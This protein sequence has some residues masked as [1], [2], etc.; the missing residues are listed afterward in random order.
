MNDLQSIR[1]A[2]ANGHTHSTDELAELLGWD[3]LKVRWTVT[4]LVSLG[5]VVPLP[6]R[7]SL[8]S[9]GDART[10]KVRMREG[11][12]EEEK[13]AHRRETQRKYYANRKAKLDASKSQAQA[14]AK[15]AALAEQKRMA[16]QEAEA[17]ALAAKQSTVQVFTPVAD[18]TMVSK[19]IANRHPLAMAWG[20]VA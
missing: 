20:G 14:K 13:V 10:R 12:T 4:K 9:L 8:T 6:K 16:K 17:A 18:D 2:L 15:R 19:A 11:M 1:A 5:D 3:I 7:Y